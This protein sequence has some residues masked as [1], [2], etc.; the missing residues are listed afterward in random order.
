MDSSDNF[1]METVFWSSNQ[2]RF[3]FLFLLNTPKRF[4]ENTFSSQT[5][6]KKDENSPV[7]PWHNGPSKWSSVISKRLL[8]ITSQNLRP[9]PCKGWF[10]FIVIAGF[11]IVRIRL[12]NFKSL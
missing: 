6:K 5:W 8:K 3:S 11:I 7:L 10:Y 4:T 12:A 1:I 2:I 9:S